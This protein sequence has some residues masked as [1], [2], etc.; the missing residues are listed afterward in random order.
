MMS[1]G[2]MMSGDGMMSGKG[3]MG[4]KGM[5]IA[6]ELVDEAPDLVEK[7]LAERLLINVTQGN[8]IR[9]LPPL[10][11]AKSEAEELVNKLA[12]ILLLTT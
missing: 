1:G 12:K 6:V 11:L 2:G 3:M 10:N 7:A 5:M 4:G 8:I 9:L